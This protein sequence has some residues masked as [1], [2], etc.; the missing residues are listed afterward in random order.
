M[1][2][3]QTAHKIIRELQV[4]CCNKSCTWQDKLE[5]LDKHYKACPYTITP[6]W[7]KDP[8]NC[9]KI[10]DEDIQ[11]SPQFPTKTPL[12]FPSSNFHS[13]PSPFC[14]YYRHCFLPN[15]YHKEL[16]SK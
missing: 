14:N 12:I 9:I 4:K 6:E 5:E 3:D 1:G 8:P 7:V 15:L 2:K 10:E 16:H 11:D 13:F